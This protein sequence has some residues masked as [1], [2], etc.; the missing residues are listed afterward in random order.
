MFTFHCE[1]ANG[2]QHHLHEYRT[3]AVCAV[4]KELKTNSTLE[5]LHLQNN[6]MFGRNNQMMFHQKDSRRVLPSRQAKQ[7]QNWRHQLQETLQGNK[8]LTKLDLRSTGLTEEQ[9][10]HMLPENIRDRW[11]G[12]GRILI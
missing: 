7:E 10:N 12:S 4:F 3:E 9:L 11:K 8:K 1:T 6:Q 5:K 2:S